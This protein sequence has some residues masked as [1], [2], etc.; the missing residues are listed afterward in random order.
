M[1]RQRTLSGFASVSAKPRTTLVDKRLS[2]Q[3]NLLPQKVTAGT[4]PQVVRAGW[5]RPDSREEGPF[6]VGPSAVTETETSRFLRRTAVRG[7]SRVQRK[8]SL[9]IEV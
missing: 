8:V 1:T 3:G 2:L 5:V 9:L 6:Q 7:P 4:L